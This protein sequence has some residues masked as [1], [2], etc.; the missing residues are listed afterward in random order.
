MNLLTGMH[1]A[2]NY[3]HPG[4][5]TSLLEII[6]RQPWSTA[7]RRR[8]QHYGWRYDYQARTIT[9]S[10][11]L[12]PLPD[13]IQG[14]ASDLQQQGWFEHTPDQVIINEYQPGQGI[15]MHKDRECF[16]PEVATLSLGDT[17]PMD[18]TPLRGTCGQPFAMTLAPGSLL[19]LKGEARNNW[20]HGIAKR[21]HDG[22]RPRQRRVSITFR[23]V[24]TGKTPP[25]ST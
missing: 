3:L 1:Y 11:R 7:L 19:I 20:M 8:T 21:T 2:Q 12:G 4:T 5:Q 25:A 17:V 6:D 9:E 15:S 16:G 10:L 23:T 22:N 14:V 13:W 18:F 24:E